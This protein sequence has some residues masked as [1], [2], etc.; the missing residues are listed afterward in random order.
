M[1]ISDQSL[2]ANT[3]EKLHISTDIFSYKK[4]PSLRP[5]YNPEEKRNQRLEVIKL[6]PIRSPSQ[7]FFKN[8]SIIE[9]EFALN[10]LEIELMRDTNINKKESMGFIRKNHFRKINNVVFIYYKNLYKKFKHLLWVLC[11]L[12]M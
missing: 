7:I 10:S 1:E 2:N 12:W 11:T 3:V 9:G 8:C 4:Y 6:L 5:V